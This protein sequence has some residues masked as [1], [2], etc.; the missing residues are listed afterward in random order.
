MNKPLSSPVGKPR[1]VDPPV[2]KT[3][4]LPTSTVAK[5]NLILFSDLEMKV[6][7]GAWSRYVNGLIRDDLEKR[8][9]V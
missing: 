2:E 4:N 5:V 8:G 3:I 9:M 6:P 7:H 1:H